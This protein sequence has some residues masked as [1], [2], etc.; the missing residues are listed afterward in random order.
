M[1]RYTH[2]HTHTHRVSDPGAI[3]RFAIIEHTHV[4]A[5]NGGITEGFVHAHK[6]VADQGGPFGGKGPDVSTSFY[7]GHT[8]ADFE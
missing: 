1:G 8:L 4:H 6:H 2:L 5:H 3:G 7:E